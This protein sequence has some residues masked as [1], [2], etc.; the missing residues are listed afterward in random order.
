MSPLGVRAVI[1]ERDELRYLL[2]KAA[3]EL[4]KVESATGGGT[5]D[6][7]SLCQ[8]DLERLASIKSQVN[9]EQVRAA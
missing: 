2:R 5:L 6:M 4:T 3:A 9:L 1:A 7:A 8:A